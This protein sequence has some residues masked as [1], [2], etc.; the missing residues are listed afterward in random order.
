M[1]SFFL[2]LMVFLKTTKKRVKSAVNRSK[3]KANTIKEHI[4]GKKENNEGADGESD[5]ENDKIVNRHGYKAKMYAFLA[6]IVGFIE[7]IP[8][9]IL[10]ALWVLILF[11]LIISVIMLLFVMNFINNLIEG[12]K[13]D[14]SINIGKDTVQ[15]DSQGIVYDGDIAW[16]EEEL[17]VRGI[18][19]TPYEKNLYRLGIL[20]SRTLQGYGGEPLFYMDGASDSLRL[21]MLIGVSST[22][23]GMNLYRGDQSKNILEYPSDIPLNSS[24]Y[25]LFG[26]SGSKKLESYF[27]D[28]IVTK[29]LR[30][31]YKP[32]VPPA[33]EAAYFPW[34]MAMSA[35]HL[36]NDLKDTVLK[37][38]NQEL[39]KTI[40]SDYG[41][42]ANR[43]EL[44]PFISF[45]L[46]QAEYHG[47][48]ESEYAAYINFLV[49]FYAATSDKD[50]E[51]SLSKWSLQGSSYAESAFR[52]A[53]LGDV[54]HRN[55]DR[56]RL[57]TD[58][59]FSNPSTKLLLNGQPLQESLWSF[60]WKKFG[61]KEG[62]KQAWEM[63]RDFASRDSNA[64]DRVLNF[65]YGINSYLQ[66]T[67]IINTLKSKLVGSPLGGQFRT[68]PGKGQAIVNGKTSEQLLDE[69]LKGKDAKV[70]QYMNELRSYWGTSAYLTNEENLA[71]KVGYKD[72]KY[73]VPFYGQGRS[74]LEGY[75]SLFWHWSKPSD[76]EGPWT[77]NR[78]GCMVYSA[79]YAASALTGR[80]IN[81]PEMAALMMIH[82]ILTDGGIIVSESPKLY[83]QMGLQAEYLPSGVN[84]KAKIDETL[85]KGGVAIVRV[86]SKSYKATAGFF[87]SSENHFIVIT[88]LINKDGGTYYSVYS[89]SDAYKSKQVYTWDF[90]QNNMHRD[91]VI[92]WR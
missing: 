81:P 6:A 49:A 52:K 76:R 37:S 59:P 42:K 3:N 5:K 53:V 65:H 44:I 83:Y 41:I 11:L 39:I 7:S 35:K 90:L 75:G 47:A 64:R 74:Y 16:T 32:K 19:L 89:S 2:A 54:D 87:T 26:I 69:W 86:T 12:L 92:V 10:V 8:I 85:R 51:R 13:F 28:S 36:Q 15:E 45:C 61:H 57:P 77:F 68:T 38:K 91:A 63:A 72:I 22:E 34:G 4:L 14:W 50:E 73:G 82:G 9:F 84:G 56:Y 20:A 58:L 78:N 60:L 17:Q 71:R 43:D 55:I 24:G 21:A 80:L 27:G 70:V 30:S 29:T 48:S 62:F 31:M 66:G 1:F 25:G 18:K 88:G 40:L 67:R 23:T 79:S 33:Y 46:A